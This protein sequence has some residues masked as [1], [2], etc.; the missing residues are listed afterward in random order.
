MPETKAF[1][2]SQES[3]PHPMEL[4]YAGLTVPISLAVAA[5]VLLILRSTLGNR[6]WRSERRHPRAGTVFHELLHLKKLH[7][8]HAVLASRHGSFRMSHFTRNFVYLVDPAGVEHIL[9]TNFSNYGKGSYCYEFLSDLFGDGI[10]AVDGGKWR[11]QR[12]LASLEF[13]TRNLRDYSSGVFSRKA[14]ALALVISEAADSERA[15]NI[16]DLLMKSTLDSIFKV[17]FGVDLDTLSGS[18]V[19]GSSFGKAFDV[20]SEVIMRRNFDVFWK[21]KRLLNIGAEAELK[22]HLKVMDE[23]VYELIQ[24][25]TEQISAQQDASTTRNSGYSDRTCDRLNRSQFRL[26]K[27]PTSDGYHRSHFR[28]RF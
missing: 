2:R 17:G 20:S 21:I 11:H 18:N 25:K 7:D 4:I 1:Q 23:F 8:Y 26:W 19:E 24:R 12:N 28:D 9:R 3:A 5:A 13:T 6:R 27:R 16:Y 10:F 14:V 22:K 15:V